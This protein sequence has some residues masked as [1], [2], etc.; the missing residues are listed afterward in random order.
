MT[1]DA[2]AP[3]DAERYE[4][5]VAALAARGRFGT[6]LGL[7]RTRALLRGLGQPQLGLRG[8]L[9]AGTN[10]K[11]SVQAMIA[12]MLGAA[13][14]RTGQSP[15]PHLLTYR[16]RI[17]VDGQPI[18]G[19]DFADLLDRV[20]HAADRIP[21]H[22]GPATEFE[23]VT[24]AAFDWFATCHVA[25]AVVEVGLG[26]RL[27]ATNAWDGGMAAIT[28][29]ALDH[30]ELLG[31]TLTHI[32]REKAAIIKRGDL[33]VSSVTGEGRLPIVRRARR[34]GVP[35][36]EVRPLA[37]E[38]MGRTGMVMHHPALGRVRVGLLGRHQAG[39]AAVAIAAVS[40]LSDAGIAH[41]SE[42]Q[43]RCGL[44]GARWPGRLELLTIDADGH[45]HPAADEQTSG[46][47]DIL[48]DG[49]HNPEGSDA[50]ALALAETWPMLSG[51]R[52]VF[53]TAVMAD[54]DVSGMVGAMM[55][56]VTSSDALVL[57]TTVPGT[58]RALGAADLAACWSDALAAAGQANGSRSTRAP[59]AIPDVDEALARAI[60]EARSGEGPIIVFG[61]LGLVG[62]V[63]GR[64]MNLVAYS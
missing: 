39:N 40:G 8:V 14:I 56:P 5:A 37:V 36:V 48:L 24:A 47:P 27:D 16:E 3:V 55:G 34:L 60:A 1:S 2:K 30:T 53:L 23:L 22:L 42:E 13:G 62:H 33:A 63:R 59:V 25:V 19:S 6:R 58:P 52:P 35:L 28:T 44:A 31:P 38:G 9:V 10:G 4:R 20:T 26:G 54:K 32:G 15:K 64:L 12:A 46:Q 29:V 7:G 11:G 50:L 17:V 51:G 18:D 57:T 43:M 21:S 49:A 41:V 45:A 61:S